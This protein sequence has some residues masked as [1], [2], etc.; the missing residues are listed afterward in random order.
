MRS[1]GLDVTSLRQLLEAGRGL[2]AELDLEALLERVLQT[3]QELTGARHAALEILGERP[4]ELERFL[5]RGVDEASLRSIGDLPRG[6]GS[7]GVPIDDPRG[8]WLDDV[9]LQARC[10]GFPDGQPPMRSLLE[11][12]ILIRGEAWG[13]LCLTEKQDG[14]FTAADEDVVVV[15]ADWAAAAIDNAHLYERE[16]ARRRELERAVGALE[17]SAA[18]A[19]AVGGETDVERILE[20]VVERGRALVEARAMLVLLRKGDHL[21]VAAAAGDT[22]RTAVGRA[23]AVDGSAF[24]RVLAGGT[25]LLI[26]DVERQLQLS[27]DE[28]GVRGVRSALVVPL[29]YRGL[30]VGVL[31]AFDRIAGGRAGGPQFTLD[32]ERL[33][34]GFAAGAAAAVATAQCAERERLRHSLES[35]ERERRRWA[36]ELHDATLQSLGALQLGLTTARRTDDRAAIDEA[37]DC[38]IEHLGEEMT[39][40]RALIID[41]RPAALDD[42]GMPAALAALVARATALYDLDVSLEL[43]LDFESGRSD[44]RHAPEIETAIYRTVQEALTNV[45]KHADAARADVEVGERDGVITI[46]VA[47]DGHGFD[48][49]AAGDGFGIIG[50]QERA[51]LAHGRMEVRSSPA[52]TTVTSLL[53]SGDRGRGSPGSVAL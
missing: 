9:G 41:L 48:A 49:A 43:D 46:V 44:R 35:A 19:R 28:L 37:I 10:Y 52:G 39:H 50:M 13:N 8:L 5:T 25:P 29:V 51:A 20:L 2:F 34:L 15:L 7:R 26:A 14:P 16:A 32:D 36:R 22:G 38:T 11:T 18:I 3:A 47:D 24:G 53:P 42:S 40:L 17:A 33:V 27:S 12:P 30:G 23:V 45:C 1:A 31:V 6:R 21:A 4:S